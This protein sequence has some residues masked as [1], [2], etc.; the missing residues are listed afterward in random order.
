VPNTGFVLAGRSLREVEKREDGI[1]QIILLGWIGM[2][3]VTFLAT[4][5][6]FRKAVRF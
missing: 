6:I 3:L 5:I 4:G 2:L 1:M